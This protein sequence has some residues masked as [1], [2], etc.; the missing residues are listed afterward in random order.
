MQKMIISAVMSAAL[1]GASGVRAEPPAPE[2]TPPA[3]QAQTPQK[4]QD[5]PPAAEKVAKADAPVCRYEAI[6]NSM[7]RRRVCR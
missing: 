7:I 1:M 4:P 6:D 2:P 5:P 3:P